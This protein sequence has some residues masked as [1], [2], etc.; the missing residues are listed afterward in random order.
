MFKSIEKTALQEIGPRFTLKLRWLRKGLPAVTGGGSV[1]SAPEQGM[2]EE[3]DGDEEEESVEAG[4]AARPSKEE[5][6]D[7]EED[8][9]AFEGADEEEEK[10]ARKKAMEGIPL[11]KQGEFEWKWKVR[12]QSHF[13]SHCR[14]GLGVWSPRGWVMALLGSRSIALLTFASISLCTQPK[15]E[16]SRKTFFL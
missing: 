3:D 11:D 10:A 2:A 9:V 4:A 6:L 8:V 12:R 13:I 15:L 16:V 14:S 5:T 7:G 1:A